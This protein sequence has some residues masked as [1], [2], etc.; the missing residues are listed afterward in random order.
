MKIVKCKAR[1]W[2]EQLKEFLGQGEAIP[3]KVM[4]AALE[5]FE[6]VEQRGD[7]ALFEQTEKFE[8]H[9]LTAATARVR[10][11]EL[12]AAQG[13]VSEA[14]MKIMR[15][16]ARRIRDFHK[17]QVPQGF[18]FKD[19]QGVS[20]EQ[21]IVALE[22]VG[23]CIPG[24]RA[25]LAS[26]VL[27]TAIPAKLAGVAQIAMI[28]PWPAGKGNAHVLA[29]AKLAGVDEIYKIGGVQGVAALALGTE[30]VASVDK[31]VGPGSIWV[32]AAKEIA[33]RRGLVGIDTLAG[34]SEIVIAA[35]AS[36]PAEYAAADMLSQ[37]EHGEDSIAILVTTDKTYAKAVT[38]SMQEQMQQLGRTEFLG[39]AVERG[40]AALICRDLEQVAEVVNFLAPE[41]L[42][43]MVS[44]PASFIK[45]IRNA[46]SIFIGPYSPVPVGDYLAGP[47]HVLPTAG[48]ARFGSPL[49]VE[50][51]IKRQSVT[52]LS[53]ASLAALAEPASRFAE[54]E[55]L[56][57][58]A[59]AV[60]K[61]LG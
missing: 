29:A 57:A 43:V 33:A 60:K 52:C 21:R 30:S 55:G 61:R 12:K 13:Q 15:L 54:V 20:L 35:D 42:E 53:R 2:Q 6:A 59:A 32:S 16:A 28:S 38:R 23:I 14:D 5:I 11:K 8:G 1:G 49:G 56:T 31:I 47:N 3:A 37:A 51:F 9:S 34:P 24:G 7:Q 39:P 10:D 58:H 50:D 36:A 22:R 18:K 41:H 40:A 26:T 48:C 44:K 25:P 17:R 27:M 4:S 45:S 46:A 19:R